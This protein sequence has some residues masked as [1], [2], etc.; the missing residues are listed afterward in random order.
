MIKKQISTMLV[1]LL[2]L[3]VAACSAVC[4]AKKVAPKKT[5]A[6]AASTHHETVGTEQ[7]KGEYGELG[8]TYTMGKTQPW[9]ICLKSAEYTIEGVNFGESTVWPKQEEKLLLLHFTVHNPQ[10]GLALMRQDVF[11]ITAIDS[12]GKNRDRETYLGSED[13]QQ[14]VAQDFKPAQKMDIYAV[15]RVPNE[16]EIPKLMLTSY[17]NFVIRYDLRTKIKGLSAPYADPSDPT[18]EKALAV[19]PA[20]MGEYYPDG[21]YAIKL[22]SISY[23]TDPIDNNK[24][25]DGQ[26]IIATISVKALTKNKPILRQDMFDL[27]VLDSDGS[28]V[29]FTG[30]LVKASSDKKVAQELDFDQEVR[31]RLVFK[32]D[33]GVTAKS[34]RIAANCN[35]KGKAYLY[36][37]E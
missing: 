9:N 18:G 31:C 28:D 20:K 35:G 34:F 5:P 16:A 2:V 23:T 33:K 8:H 36:T 26:F 27:K 14:V 21:V 10:K 4:A 37:L 22:E 32:A 3:S 19:I 17:D 6:K 24:P 30:M 25:G 15:I 29:K 12:N 7:L 1:C 11:K 13:K